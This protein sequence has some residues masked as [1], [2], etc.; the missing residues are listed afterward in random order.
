M[1]DA[2]NFYCLWIDAVIHVACVVSWTSISTDKLSWLQTFLSA[3]LNGLKQIEQLMVLL[4][5]LHCSLVSRFI[6]ILLA[7]CCLQMVAV[8]K[9]WPKPFSGVFS[10]IH[11]G[12]FKVLSITAFHVVAASSWYVL[13]VLDGEGFWWLWLTRVLLT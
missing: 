1:N 9:T 13:L 12:C 7:R 6:G 10:Y 4:Y 5:S 11:L 8:A 2:W 3:D